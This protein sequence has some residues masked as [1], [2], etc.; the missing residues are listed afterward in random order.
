[1]RDLLLERQ[2]VDFDVATSARPEQV[3]A[4]FGHKRTLAVGAA[5]GVIIVLGKDSA[6][7]QVEVATFR[8]DAQYSD[9]RRPD[10]VTFSTAKEDAARRDFT[11]NAC[12][13]I[14]SISKSSTMS[15]DK[16]I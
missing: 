8:N 10:S 14:R 1:M 3:R 5:F 13:M 12:S 4:L 7:G 9:G 16:P 15:M 6:A 11:I 2:P